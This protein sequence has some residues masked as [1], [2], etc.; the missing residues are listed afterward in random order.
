M[1]GPLPPEIRDS[2]AF[3]GEPDTGP[4]GRERELAWEAVTQDFQDPQASTRPSLDGFPD[5][6]RR[7]LVKDDRSFWIIPVCDEEARPFVCLVL[8]GQRRPGIPSC[9]TVEKA[10]EGKIAIAGILEVNRWFHAVLVADGDEAAVHVGDTVI[11]GEPVNNVL[12]VEY[13]GTDEEHGNARVVMGGGEP[14][15]DCEPV[16]TQEPAPAT[17]VDRIA[18]LRQEPD[19]PT[20]F[21]LD[22]PDVSTIYAGS[23]RIAR[24]G[25]GAR[26]FVIPVMLGKCENPQPGVCLV[27]MA[28]G[29]QTVC[30][31]LSGGASDPFVVATT[32]TEAGRTDVI[33]VAGDSV[34][35]VDVVYPLADGS[36]TGLRVEV[37]A[38]TFSATVAEADGEVSV[39]PAG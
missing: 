8:V 18:V 4:E 21:K 2:F 26:A 31:Q 13:T 27:P 24:F 23:T 33:G 25:S 35:A 15:E 14:V 22:E 11:S 1:G 3:L 12:Y 30:G 36:T 34:R 37:E 38:G 28:R 6:V 32:R 17:I 19:P 20:D 5:H 39:K 9:G 16:A 10:R 29:F 7:A